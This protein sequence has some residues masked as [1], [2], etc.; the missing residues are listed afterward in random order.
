M[1]D[2]ID[3]DL[4]I[5]KIINR[6][7]REPK[8]LIEDVNSYLQGKA[9]MQLEIIDVIRDIPQADTSNYIKI[10]EEIDDAAEKLGEILKL[11]TDMLAE[12]LQ[13]FKNNPEDLKNACK[14]ELY[15]ELK[16]L[17]LNL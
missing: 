9:Q 11:I 2:L 6:K 3:R 17:L 14:D 10:P 8:G 5:Q 16:G 4:V 7:S 1:D 15:N 13:E 12:V